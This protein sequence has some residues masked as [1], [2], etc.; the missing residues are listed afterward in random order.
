[1]PGMS[2]RAW[3]A[4]SSP[5]SPGGTMST[6]VA[7]VPGRGMARPA[8]SLATRRMAAPPIEAVGS[9]GDRDG[10]AGGFAHRVAAP[11]RGPGE[12][13]SAVDLLGAGKIEVELVD[14]G[15]FHHRG[16]GHKHRANLPVLHPAGFAGHRDESRAGTKPRSTGDRH[17]GA[18]PEGPR[19]IRS[20]ADYPST[21]RSA[22]HHDMPGLPGALVIHQPS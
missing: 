14:A 5:S 12:R 6:P 22:S 4:R 21:V 11:G 15:G 16:P 10:E 9:A 8:A 19:F 18:K 7:P 3:S 1:M 20:R 17:P 2:A 13:P